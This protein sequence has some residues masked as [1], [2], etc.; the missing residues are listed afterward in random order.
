M[1]VKRG[2]TLH[3]RGALVRPEPKVFGSGR[4]IGAKVKFMG[5]PPCKR[6]C[7][8]NEYN[9]FHF[10]DVITSFGE[11]CPIRFLFLP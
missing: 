7:V 6:F 2:V 3:P 11:V 4:F 5:E 9:Q 10:C 1:I 8:F